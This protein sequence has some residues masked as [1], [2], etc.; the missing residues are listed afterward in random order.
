M[1]ISHGYQ[2]IRL[3]KFFEKN[4]KLYKYYNLVD[5]INTKPIPSKLIKIIASYDEILTIDEQTEQGSLGSAVLEF[6]NKKIKKKIKVNCY[7]LNENF[8]FDNGGRE[9]L[10]NANGLNLSNIFKV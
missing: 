9:K 8:I 2:F 1:I 4:T 7:H 5:L 3:K 10:L 6:L